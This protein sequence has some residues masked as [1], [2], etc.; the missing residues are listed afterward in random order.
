M[1]L[2]KL[3]HKL[4]T[5]N[6]LLNKSYIELPELLIGKEFV[7]ITDSNLIRIYQDFLW[8]YKT[9]VVPAGEQ[10]KKLSEVE[11]IY[12]KLIEY[13]V[14]REFYIVAFGGGVVLDIAGFV[15]N[16]FLRGLKLISIPTTLLSQTDASIG[17]KNGVNF[18][19]FK[20]LIGTYHQP[21]FVLCDT[22]LLKTLPDKELRNALAESVKAGLVYSEEFFTY[23]ET[24]FENYIT[25]NSISEV[26]FEP[27]VLNN[28]IKQS[29]EI[30]ITIVETD[31]FDFS[32]RRI[33]NFGH[34]IG[35]SIESIYGMR[36]GESVSIGMVTA[37]R[38]SNKIGLLSDSQEKRIKNLL[39]KIG[40]PV[41]FIFDTD[42]IMKFIERDKKRKSTF[43]N[44]IVLEDIGKARIFEISFSELKKMLNDL[45]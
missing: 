9:I 39:Y 30:K 15:A 5:S 19:K 7:I 21:E 27:V 17:G 43:L 29:I 22:N 26:L 41:D 16:T 13:E 14:N 3:N 45:R 4:G 33:L 34:T 32:L 28:I 35:H 6:I 36:H 10:F 23:L 40:L 37:A 11:L 44:F 20:N 8:K 18:N 12:Q 2:I 24:T 25:T 1:N 31:E 38:I 42:L